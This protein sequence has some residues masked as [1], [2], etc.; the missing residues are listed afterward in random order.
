MHFTFCRRFFRWRC[1]CFCVFPN[2]IVQLKG[3][4]I[5]IKWGMLLT[6][7]TFLF[8]FYEPVWIK[9]YLNVCK[10]SQ[11]KGDSIT[12]KCISS[13]LLCFIV[14]DSRQGGWYNPQDGR[15][16]SSEALCEGVRGDDGWNIRQ[17]RKGHKHAQSWSSELHRVHQ[18]L[19]PQSPVRGPGWLRQGLHLCSG[20]GTEPRVQH[21]VERCHINLFE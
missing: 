7:A 17:V 5:R 3:F 2:L 6:I 11:G 8:R 20:L 16:S 14:Q 21:Q 9:R 13:Q 1:K 19:R 10:K 15:Q 12:R 4:C 18:A